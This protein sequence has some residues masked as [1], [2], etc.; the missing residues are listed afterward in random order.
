[1]RITRFFVPVSV[2]LALMAC[3]NS[4]TPTPKS[5]SVVKPV[6]VVTTT[7]VLENLVRRIGH[8]VA[9]LKVSLAF[10]THGKCLHEHQIS[11]EEMRNLCSASLVVA[12]GVNFE[13]FLDQAMRQCPQI[14][15][16]RVGDNCA[17]MPATDGGTDPHAWFGSKNI[18]CMASNLTKA[19]AQYDTLH[20]TA[21]NANGEAVQKQLSDFWNTVHNGNASLRGLPV[22]SFHGAYNYLAREL[23]MN[24]V[25]TFGEEQEDVTPSAKQI[26]ELISKIKAQKVSLLM[27]GENETPDLAAAVARETGVRVIRL[28]NMMEGLDTNDSQAYEH[29]IQDDISRL[30]GQP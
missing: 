23:G 8:D 14:P 30:T 2:A 25:A 16:V 26:A 10:Q 22:V 15:V 29:A 11:T 7:P 24:M 5:T 4:K 21:Y 18:D 13:P 6:G 9:G 3:G 12:N 17:D 19:L 1:M 27:L 28:R 20:A